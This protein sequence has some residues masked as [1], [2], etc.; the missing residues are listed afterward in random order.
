MLVHRQIIVPLCWQHRNANTH[1][2]VIHCAALVLSSWDQAQ[3]SIQSTYIGIPGEKKGHLENKG[4]D[5][6]AVILVSPC[7]WGLLWEGPCLEV[8]YEHPAEGLRSVP[9]SQWIFF[10]CSAVAPQDTVPFLIPTKKDFT[11]LMNL[12]LSASGAAGRLETTLVCDFFFFLPKRFCFFKM[13]RN[14]I[15][16]NLPQREPLASR[17]WKKKNLVSL[18]FKG[19]LHDVSSF[20][21]AEVYLRILCF[22]LRYHAK[23]CIWGAAVWHFCVAAG[24]CCCCWCLLLC[25]Y[26]LYITSPVLCACLAR[27]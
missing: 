21:Q 3:R 14:Y 2:M 12:C 25:R 15:N 4:F 20:E 17:F 13:T 9:A 18:Q 23:I 26:H 8:I 16:Y 19:R 6:R 27:V 24:R 11:L 5:K 7:M 10:S 22:W 1:S